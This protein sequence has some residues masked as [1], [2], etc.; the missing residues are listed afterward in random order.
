M[1]HTGSALI[2][3][4]F[5]D[6][7]RRRPKGARPT[8]AMMMRGERRDESCAHLHASIT[9]SHRPKATGTRDRCCWRALRR[10][11]VRAVH[12]PRLTSVAK[13]QKILITAMQKW[14]SRGT[15]FNNAGVRPT[16]II[17][18]H[19]FALL[20]MRARASLSPSRAAAAEGCW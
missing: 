19:T 17:I 7:K 4:R 9:P 10:E 11:P 16:Y 3:I 5:N 14:R 12:L 2:S 6:E 13:R 8:T 20:L 18:A 1:Q 15:D